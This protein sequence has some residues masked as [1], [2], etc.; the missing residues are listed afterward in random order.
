MYRFIMKAGITNRGTKYAMGNNIALDIPL[1][2]KITIKKQTFSQLL[3]KRGLISLEICVLSE[4]YS[5]LYK[6]SAAQTWSY[7]VFSIIFIPLD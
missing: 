3:L 6:F 4:N 2:K 5:N 1:T 7:Y